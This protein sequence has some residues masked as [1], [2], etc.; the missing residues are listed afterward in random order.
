MY[1]LLSDFEYSLNSRNSCNLDSVLHKFLVSAKLR[2][3][4][5]NCD[6]AVVRVSEL[7][8][9]THLVGCV[10]VGGLPIKKEFVMFWEFFGLLG[11]ET[12]LYTVF[13]EYCVS[14]R[15]KALAADVFYLV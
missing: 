9:W 15:E 14:H 6:S 11:V 10:S 3:L 2:P 4:F 13:C 7:R 8:L 1:I 12:F 5:S